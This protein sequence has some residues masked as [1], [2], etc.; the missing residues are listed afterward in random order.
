M[1]WLQS[2]CRGPGGTYRL[3]VGERGLFLLALPGTSQQSFER[4]AT[5]ILSLDAESRSGL[6]TDPEAWLDRYRDLIENWGPL[7]AQQVH[8]RPPPL[9]LRGSRFQLQ[10]WRTLLRVPPG[11]TISY[12]RLAALAGSPGA[13]RAVGTAMRKNRIPVLVPCH[14]VVASNGP[15]GYGGGL[16]LKESLLRL[17]AGLKSACAGS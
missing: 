2:D 8:D 12:G 13:A 17:E 7:T 10:V 15:G 3:A 5:G 9:D 14:R 1:E 4:E 16:D 11:E 6:R